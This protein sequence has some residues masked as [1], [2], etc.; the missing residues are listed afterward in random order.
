MLPAVDYDA[1]HITGAIN[2][3]IEEIN[4][5]TT[6]HLDKHHPLIVYCW[7]MQ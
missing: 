3:P 2:L 5:Q 1:E 7:D 6:A 4:A